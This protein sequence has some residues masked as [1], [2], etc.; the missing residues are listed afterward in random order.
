MPGYVIHLSIAEE[1]LRKHKNKP[2]NYK[3]FIEGIIFPDSI[4]EKYKTHYANINEGSSKANLY[5]FLQDRQLNTS[6]NRGYF[7]HLLT[8]YLFYNKYIDTF[9]ND[10]YNDY[11]ILNDT[12]IKK[13][14]VILPEEVKNSVFLK[15]G[16]LK[17]LNLELV[18]RLIDEISDLDLEDTENKIKEN[19]EEWTRI[20]ELKH[21]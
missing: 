20:R 11:D 19:P 15:K 17:I 14:K 9:S 3:E 1:Y 13:Y 10:M 12:L 21:K 16:E 18:E 5:R 2:E 8:D 4:K 7:L 6:F